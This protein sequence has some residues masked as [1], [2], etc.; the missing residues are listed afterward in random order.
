M[1]PKFDLGNTVITPNAAD[2]IEPDDV[3]AALDRHI[4]GDWG[5]C[6][7]QE[8]DANDQALRDGLR[9]RSVY[10][11]KTGLQFLVVTEPDRSA[12]TIQLMP[13]N[14]RDDPMQIPIV[15]RYADGDVHELPEGHPLRF[16]RLT[17]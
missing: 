11:T 4:V 3:L 9:L 15:E 7:K 10:R 2:N 17:F 13:K 5:E 12:T 8:S 16:G 14:G 1:K 6:S